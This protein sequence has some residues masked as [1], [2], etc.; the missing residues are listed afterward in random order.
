MEVREL[1]GVFVVLFADGK[2]V[3]YQACVRIIAPGVSNARLLS[4][5]NVEAVSDKEC[6]LHASGCAV[7]INGKP[8]PGD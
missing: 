4:R 3:E 2:S 8:G 6:V 5:Y 7:E 1:T